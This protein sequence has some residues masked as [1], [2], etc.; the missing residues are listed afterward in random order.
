MEKLEAVRM[1]HV[2]VINPQAGG[3]DR[4]HQINEQLKKLALET[5]VYIT[6]GP[7][8]ATHYVADRCNHSDGEELRFYACGGDGTL[9][10]VVSG[11]MSSEA[12]VRNAEVGCYPCGSGNDFIKYWPEA[13]FTNLE[14]LVA[15]TS[16]SVDVMKFGDRYSL[17]TLNFG[18]EAAVCRAMSE[19]RRLPILGGRMAYT[20]GILKSLA[21][22]RRN[23]CH[24]E[25]DGEL[26]Y[27]GDLL[28]LSLANGQYT[29]GGYH[30]APQALVD[31]GLIEVLSVKPMSIPTFAR[32]IKYYENGELLDRPELK[33]VVSYRRGQR[34]TIE[35][36]RLSFV[37]TDGELVEGQRFEIEMQ[38]KAIRFVVPTS[39]TN[40]R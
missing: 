25:V 29:G 20:T 14:A 16:T 24:V 18:F 15:G 9:N 27:E 21:T 11:I 22:G 6:Q 40:N 30:C 31:D 13:D 3:H 12:G 2:F 23:H 38:H 10:E 1:R 37:A 36:G 35:V 33:K 7:R 19:V 39:I 28:L 5:E 34:V 17:N 26:W 4:S 8:D 32:L